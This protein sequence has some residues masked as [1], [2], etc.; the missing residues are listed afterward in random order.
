MLLLIAKT[1][2]NDV[3]NTALFVVLFTA[4]L[5]LGLTFTVFEL[6]QARIYRHG[7][8]LIRGYQQADNYR[9]PFRDEVVALAA[10]L[11]NYIGNRARNILEL[12]MGFDN[13]AQAA[14]IQ[15][16]TANRDR[17]YQR[18]APDKPQSWQL[19]QDCLWLLDHR[20][21]RDLRLAM[22]FADID[23]DEVLRNVRGNVN[24]HA[25]D[26]RAAEMEPA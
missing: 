4:L 26:E 11:E 20:G 8:Q 12:D 7:V 3:T 9:R 21:D 6:R 24:T 10:Y 5:L 25:N 16:L 23:L 22:V 1:N 17:L 14:L 2:P 15:E 18:L 13:F 19:T